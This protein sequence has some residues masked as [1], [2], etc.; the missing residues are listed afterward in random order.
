MFSS[1]AIIVI[2]GATLTFENELDKQGLGIGEARYLNKRA[3]DV[4]IDPRD[5]KCEAICN[6]D[7]YCFFF[8]VENDVCRT[9]KTFDSEV[10]FRL[11]ARKPGWIRKSSL[12]HL[13][14]VMMFF[15]PFFVLCKRPQ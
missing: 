13:N 2:V 12:H 10:E 5:A 9:F 4:G 15:A 14:S 3:E 1:Y 7:D 6:S 11:Y 8:G